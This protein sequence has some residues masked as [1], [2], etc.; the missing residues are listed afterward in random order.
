VQCDEGTRVRTHPVIY[1]I[2]RMASISRGFYDSS[3]W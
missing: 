1:L 3:F 2:K